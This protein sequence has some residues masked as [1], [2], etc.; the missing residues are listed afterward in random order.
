MDVGAFSDAVGRPGSDIRTTLS[1]VAL[2]ELLFAVHTGRFTGAVRLGGLPE[3]DRLC[4]RDGAF[5]GMRP[6]PSVDGAGLQAALLSLRLLS[7]ATLAALTDD[8]PCPPKALAKVLVEHR[9]VT[10]ADL[11]RAIDEHTRRRLFAL[12]DLPPATPVRALQGL[13]HVAEFWPV[14]IDV[15]PVVAFGVVAR[16][17]AFRRAAMMDKVKGRTVRLQS[18]YDETRNSYGL[19]PPILYALK[20]LQRGVSLDRSDS[21]PGLSVEET[22]GVLLLLDRMALLHIE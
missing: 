17:N 8:G 15:R 14:S 16:A 1:E 22:A 2:D 13:D 19:P 7:R 6:R 21:L 4:F 20:S 18:P 12:Y 5:V 9:M 11:Q 10:A 3:A